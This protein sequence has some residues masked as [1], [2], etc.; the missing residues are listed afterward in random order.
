MAT[1]EQLPDAERLAARLSHWGERLHAAGLGG[2]M[3]ALLD[4]AEPLAP[5]GAQA[6]W[7]AQPA[8]GLVLPRDA[9]AD[10]ARVLDAPGGVAWLRERLT[11]AQD[12]ADR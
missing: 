9:V 5:L 11:V 1:V 7:V 3:A 2:V 4:A 6:L 12:E 10:L 8:L